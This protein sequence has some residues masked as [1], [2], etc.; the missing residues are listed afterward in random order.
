MG[1]RFDHLVVSVPDVGDAISRWQVAGLD[2]TAGGRHRGGTVNALVRG[3]RP[4]YVELISTDPTAPPPAGSA[5][6]ERV[7]GEYGPL[8]FAVAVDHLEE[9]REALLTA[10][11]APSEIADGSRVTPE[12]ATIRWRICQVGE[13]AFDPYLPFLIEWVEGMPPGPADGP[14]LQSVSIA[15]G[16]DSAARDR[17]ARLLRVLGFTERVDRSPGMTFEDGQVSIWLPATRAEIA[18]WEQETGGASA[19]LRWSDGDSEE[20]A[21]PFGP[22][23]IAIGL[24]HGDTSWHELDGLSVTTFPDLRAHVGH[25]LLPAVEEHFAAR[26]PELRTWPHPHPDRE[27][28]DEEYSRCLDPA[29]YRIVVARARAWA[30]ALVESGVAEAVEHPSGLDLIPTTEGAL[31]LTVRIEGFEG[32]P[33][34]LVGLEVGG[35]VLARLPDCGC[36]ACDDGSAGL[37]EALDD[38]V[39]HVLDGGVLRVIGPDGREVTTTGNGWSASGTFARGEPEQWVADA[40]AGRSPYEVIQGAA[41][42]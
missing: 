10:G 7:S 33:D 15:I 22:A 9:A 42:L 39:L 37:L 41:W 3:P 40:R 20:E 35:T 34:N 36:D 31:P 18:A 6:A 2:A 5:W 11:F 25:V 12:G 1:A 38:V 19:Y 24:P 27:P 29:K 14:V 32:I 4:A 30:A 28:L 26:P 21:T 13:R 17:L 23:S 16:E 8:G